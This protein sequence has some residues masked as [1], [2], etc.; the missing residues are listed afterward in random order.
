M[1]EKLE[2]TCPKCGNRIVKGDD[3]E[4]K[5]R[6]QL[7]KWNHNGCFAVC[8]GCKADIEIDFAVL[9]K[10]NTYYTFEVDRN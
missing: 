6:V 1:K 4:I 5:M 9:R 2:V 8:K 10:L 3:E 7:L